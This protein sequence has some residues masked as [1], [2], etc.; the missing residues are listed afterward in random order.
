M[1]PDYVYPDP[2][3]CGELEPVL[4]ERYWIPTSPS[5]MLMAVICESCSLTGPWSFSV[6]G[7]AL[8]WN[9]LVFNLQTVKATT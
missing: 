2:C 7:A 6:M 9:C 3:P 4:L 5:G 1:M 8:G